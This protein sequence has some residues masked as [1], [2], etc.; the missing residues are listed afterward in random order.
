[1]TAMLNSYNEDGARAKLE[2]IFEEMYCLGI[3]VRMPNINQSQYYATAYSST[4][5]DEKSAYGIQLGFNAI[6]GISE[7]LAEEIVSTRNKAVPIAVL[8]ILYVVFH[9]NIAMQGMSITSLEPVLLIASTPAG[10]LLPNVAMTLSRRKGNTE[11]HNPM[12][13]VIYCRM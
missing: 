13:R 3:H 1:M 11:Q 7:Q 9:W 5:D 12:D 6:R 10:R 8:M 2:S 4:G